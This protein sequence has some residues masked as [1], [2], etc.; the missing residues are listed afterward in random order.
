MSELSHGR[1]ARLAA[2]TLLA[3]AACSGG[4]RSLPPGAT[5]VPVVERDFNISVPRHL[6]AGHVVLSVRNDG[7]TMHELIVVRAHD[8]QLPFRASGLTV[9]EEALEPEIAGA[10]EPGAPGEV[11]HLDVRL[12]P[13]RYEFICN[14]TGHYLGGMETDVVV[15]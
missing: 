13:G 6:N 10:L 7:P 2:L 11:R 15:K 8:S 4:Q 3:L 12:R 14:M 1:R 5:S 9:D